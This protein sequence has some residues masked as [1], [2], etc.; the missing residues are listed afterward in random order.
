MTNRLMVLLKKVIRSIVYG[1]T[2]LIVIVLIWYFFIADERTLTSTKPPRYETFI[3]T[4]VS[5]PQQFVLPGRLFYAVW[6]DYKIEGF[7]D[8]SIT[9]CFNTERYD[10]ESMRFKG[11]VETSN[12]RDFYETEDII[13]TYVPNKAKK[14]N[15]IIKACIY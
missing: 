9:V 15:L 6:L 1:V 14:G 7:V 12:K 4:D 8:D 10:Y 11:K 2:T 3:V 13:I 5:K